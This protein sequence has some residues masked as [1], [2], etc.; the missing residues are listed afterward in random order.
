MLVLDE[1]KQKWR[2]DIM[3]EPGNEQLWVY[4]RTP[5]ITVPRTEIVRRSA[6]GI[7]YLA[8]EGVL[9]FKGGPKHRRKDE[10]D[11]RA[12]LPFLSENAKRWLAQCLEELYPGHFQTEKWIEALK[13]L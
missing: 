13:Q 6:L 7:P 11:F 9:Q 1:E 3:R 5:T 2:V 10:G 12:C 4:R 8:P